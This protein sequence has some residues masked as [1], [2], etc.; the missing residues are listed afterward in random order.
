MGKKSDS[1]KVRGQEA[2]PRWRALFLSC[3]L[4][5]VCK[6]SSD[7][8]NA[9][10]GQG[11]DQR[12]AR[13]EATPSTSQQG[14]Q[15][16]RRES[17]KEKKA[18]TKE[19]KLR[20]KEGKREQDRMRNTPVWF[21]RV[22]GRPR[23]QEMDQKRLV[24]NFNMY[25]R[26]ELIKANR[27]WNAMP[28]RDDEAVRKVTFR[29]PSPPGPV[30]VFLP[31]RRAVCRRDLEWRGEEC[32]ADAVQ[33]RQLETESEAPV[34]AAVVTKEETEPMFQPVMSRANDD[35]RVTVPHV[36]G[37][38]ITFFMSIGF[39]FLLCFLEE[40]FDFRDLNPRGNEKRRPAILADTGVNRCRGTGK[41]HCNRGF[42]SILSDSSSIMKLP[43][44][45]ETS[46]RDYSISTPDLLW[47]EPRPEQHQ[48]T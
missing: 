27:M 26:M 24:G 46:L 7:Q 3:F 11:G 44:V 17:A 23:R 42:L 15:A 29:A 30:E 37:T 22:V 38:C 4:C 45:P 8:D 39:F 34:V 9:E 32:L 1:E 36:V 10:D 6:C 18:R 31:A 25:M 16:P 14:P 35:T 43:P 48:T 13:E 21:A 5:G 47:S 19:A 28:L 2:T 20:E 40:L 41:E 12:A 33:I